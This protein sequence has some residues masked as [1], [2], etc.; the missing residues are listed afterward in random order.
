MRTVAQLQST[1]AGD[2]G[3]R[4]TE[5][6]AAQDRAG[7]GPTRYPVRRPWGREWPSGR[8]RDTRAPSPAR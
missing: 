7:E 6:T 8:A 2:G 3:R 4:C 1:G 5:R